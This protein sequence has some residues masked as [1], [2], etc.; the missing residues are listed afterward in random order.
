M[1]TSEQSSCFCDPHSHA[2]L[3]LIFEKD[4]K[5]KDLYLLVDSE[6]TCRYP[7]VDGI[8]RI[9]NQRDVVG[10]NKRYQDLYYRFALFYR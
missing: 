6:G 5:G 8:V 1:F 10:R 9:L 3:K 2:P 7:I 4:S